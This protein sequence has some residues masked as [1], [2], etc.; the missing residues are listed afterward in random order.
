M[1]YCISFLAS[2]AV[3]AAFCSCDDMLETKN[4]TDM[5]AENF[6]QSEGDFDAAVTA[7]YLPLTVNWG[8]GDGGTG[9]WL[10]ALFNADQNAMLPGNEYTTDEMRTYSDGHDYM[11]FL[12]GPS[13]SWGPIISTFN[14]MRFIARA[15]D[16]I[17][18]IERSTASTQAIRDR[19]V[20]EAKTLRAYY[21]FVILDYF[22][23]MNVKLDPARLSDNTIDPRPDTETYVGY[24]HQD[25]ADAI[26]CDALPDKYNGDAENWGRMSKAIAYA[27]RMKVNMH[28]KSWSAALADCNQLMQM[29]YSLNSDYYDCFNQDQTSEAIWS[30]PSNSA[31]DNFYV[32]ELLPSDFKMGY[33]HLGGSY[34]KGTDSYWY[35]GWQAY[36]MRWDFY[37]TFA[38]ND[39]RKQGILCEYLSNDGTV[40]SREGTNKMVGPIPL[41][42]TDSQVAEYGVQS[43]WP[44]I[45]YADVLLSYAEC[46]NELNGPSASAQAAVKQVTDRANAEIPT[47]AVASKDS[48]R[49]FLLAERG[50][51][52]YAEGHRRQDLIRH[53]TYISSAIE[54]GYNAKDYQVL[55]P[56]PQFAITEAGGILKQNDGY[57]E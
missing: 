23:P 27:I 40:K 1:K 56:I 41:K 24:I 11:E 25:L 14:M 48:F 12:V 35:S 57:T 5:V 55:F 46:E 8:Y 31:Y 7:L 54:R 9:N 6:F 28:Q 42:F 45:R 36:C 34:I 32:I 33:N 19:Y 22:G 43:A 13:T 29:G 53:G 37:D 38:D 18:N 17:D 39:V 26:S 16:V 20:A 50:R 3:T 47:L 51:E 21:M 15:T 52:L 44:V 4:Y 49:D 10:N 2:L 30:V